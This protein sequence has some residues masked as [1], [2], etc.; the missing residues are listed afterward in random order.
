[1]RTANRVAGLS[2]RVVLLAVFGLALAGTAA[3]RDLPLV[4][5]ARAPHAHPVYRSEYVET[6]RCIPQGYHLVFMVNQSLKLMNQWVSR[7]HC[8]QTIKYASEGSTLA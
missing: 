7:I 8:I 5:A 2:L 1:M 6:N 3:A 4:E